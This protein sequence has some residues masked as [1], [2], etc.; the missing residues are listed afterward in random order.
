M[1]LCKIK[2]SVGA[3]NEAIRATFGEILRTGEEGPERESLLDAVRVV[4]RSQVLEAVRCLVEQRGRLGALT[5][6]GLY[7]LPEEEIL[8]RWNGA[9][10]ERI[11]ET[12]AG[13]D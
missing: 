4:G 5:E 1:F 3:L 11:E 9:V 6:G 10:A 8:S 7:S 2:R 13:I 12:C